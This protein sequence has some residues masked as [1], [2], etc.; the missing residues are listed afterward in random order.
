MGHPGHEQDLKTWFTCTS[1]I[2]WRSF[3][4]LCSDYRPLCE[5]RIAIVSPWQSI[6]YFGTFDI[7]YSSAYDKKKSNHLCNFCLSVHSCPDQTET[8]EWSHGVNQDTLLSG[9]NLWELI[10]FTWCCTVDTMFPP[11]TTPCVFKGIRNKAVFKVCNVTLT[12]TL[13]CEGQM[14]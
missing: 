14:L 5:V 7:S 12:C 9:S 1:L 4:A 3:H 11:Y 13:Y 8:T 10:E 2:V 6:L